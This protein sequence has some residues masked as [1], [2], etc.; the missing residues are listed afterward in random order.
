MPHL[1]CT[2][3]SSS[4]FG[5]RYQTPL[6][7]PSHPPHSASLSFG[8]VSN[9]IL[10]A[11]HLRQEHRHEHI[12]SFGEVSNVILDAHHLRRS[13]NV[14]AYIHSRDIPMFT[15]RRR[16][17]DIYLSSPTH[18]H[19]ENAHRIHLSQ[20]TIAPHQAAVVSQ[21]HVIHI[22]PSKSHALQSTRRSR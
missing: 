18:M 15:S 12:P 10:D 21:H 17:S 22:S 20:L 11:N 5:A 2:S 8:V 7:L 3:Q 1:A 6:R 4:S 13:K 14:N 9:V 19:F 16:L